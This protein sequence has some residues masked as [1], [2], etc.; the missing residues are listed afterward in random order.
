MDETALRLGLGSLERH[1]LSSWMEGWLEERRPHIAPR[2]HGAYAEAVR[3][4]TE[5]VGDKSLE[6]VTPADV[7][8]FTSHLRSLGRNPSTINKIVRFYLS[9]PFA[10]A[11]K[12]GLIRYNPVAATQAEKTERA[13]KE[14]FTPAQVRALLAVADNDWQGLIRFAWGT[15]ARLGD[16]TRLKWSSIDRDHDVVSFRQGKTGKVA[17]VGLHPDFSE[18]LCTQPVPIDLSLSVFP[19]LSSRPLHE[20]SHAFGRLMVAAGIENRVLRP[21][22]GTGG[23]SVMALSFHSFRHSAASNVFNQA[24]LRDIARRVT[25][26]A[27]GGAV[28]RYLHTDLEAIR[29]ATSLIP[30]LP[31]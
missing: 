18:W 6:A 13:E 29:A 27:A 28:S 26:H 20:L 8:K 10:R 21:S 3:Q 14:T 7:A 12:L 24:A 2:T 9:Q 30:K 4:F 22:G 1:T 15:G 11:L 16:A 25:A 31:K 5:F 19:S 23:R 17:L